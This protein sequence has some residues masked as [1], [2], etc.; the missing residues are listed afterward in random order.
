[1]RTAAVLAAA[2]VALTALRGQAQEDGSPYEAVVKDMLTATDKLTAVLTTIKDATSAG[3][4]RPEL[5]K[6]VRQLLEV[7]AKAQALKQ[8]DRAQ[9]ERVAFAYRRKLEEA[10]SRFLQ[11]RSR[12]GTIPGGRDAL[13][14]LVPLQERKGDSPRPETKPKG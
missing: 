8:P 3:A 4:A 5:K 10:V 13:Q 14:E 7:R 11:E 6:A 9:R 12:V 2:L 1:M